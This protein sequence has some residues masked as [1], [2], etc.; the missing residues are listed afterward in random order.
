MIKTCTTCGHVGEPTWRDGVYHCP[1]CDTVIDMTTPSP[2]QNTYT[3]GANGTPIAAACPVCRNNAGNTLVNGRCVCSMCGT[4][5]DYAASA[6]TP[7]YPQ[8]PYSGGYNYA[9]YRD[10]LLRQRNHN[11]NWG[12]FWLIMC[13]PVSI[14]FFVKMSSIS[15]EINRLDLQNRYR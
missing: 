1:M 5:F 11:R 14:F 13:W 15:A 3:P 9:A 12:I 10:A 7:S 2:A 8:P 6:P 4:T